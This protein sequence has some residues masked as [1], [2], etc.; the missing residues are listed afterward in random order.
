MRILLTIFF[1]IG[2]LLTLCGQNSNNILVAYED[3]LQELGPEI[4]YGSND[5]L[6]HAANNKFISILTKA[7]K[8]PNSFDYPFDKLITISRL[9][10]LDNTFRI[11]NWNLPKQ[12]GT[13]E[14]FCI[15]Q[16]FSK[17]FEK[18][19]IFNLNDQSTTIT[20]P[21]NASLTSQDWY[22]AHYFELIGI[23]NRRNKYYTLLGWDGNDLL[24][25]KK[26]IDILYFGAAGEPKFGKQVLETEE[27]F[28][29][30]IIFEY[31]AQAVM[32][33]KFYKKKRTLVFDHI[34]PAKQSLKGIGAY[35]GPDGS[36]DALKFKRGKWQLI[37][38][39]DA[40]N[41]KTH[42]KEKFQLPE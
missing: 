13:Y 30:R 8:T 15:I 11:F 4:L 18:Y 5:S 40:K 20:N 29:N 14:Y 36:Y 42:K 12:D 19:Q 31:N 27:G 6:K 28:R 37:L 1:I 25:T 7:L 23:K 38:N 17:R 39:F 34:S 41:L 26:I 3:S 16:A 35:Q 2:A 24:S 9:S 33:I 10:P 32:S 21:Q 22:G